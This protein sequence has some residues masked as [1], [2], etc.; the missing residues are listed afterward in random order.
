MRHPPRVSRHPRLDHQVPVTTHPVIICFAGSRHAPPLRSLLYDPRRRHAHLRH[1][2]A[3]TP[4]QHARPTSKA[5]YAARPTAYCLSYPKATQLINSRFP[6]RY[7]ASISIV[8]PHS[9]CLLHVPCF[10]THPHTPPLLSVSHHDPAPT[11]TPTLTLALAC[12]GPPRCALAVAA[13][14]PLLDG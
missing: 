2:A 1:C 6:S 13:G 12:P 11:P 9:A 5:R 10:I 3:R 4:G 7:V 14:S 8:P